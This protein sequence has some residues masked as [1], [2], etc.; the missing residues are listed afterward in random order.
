[1]QV[2]VEEEYG[3]AD[4]IWNP[5]FET[6]EDFVSWWN[7][8]DKKKIQKSVFESMPTQIGERSPHKTITERRIDS[9]KRTFGG[10]WELVEYSTDFQSSVDRLHACDAYMHIH[11]DFDS[12]ITVMTVPGQEWE[13]RDSEIPWP[14]E[15]EQE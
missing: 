10:K 5:P 2:W 15:G 7:K 12:Y 4:Y 6:H 14:N 13:R 11:E 3:Y 1:M 9:Y 8:L